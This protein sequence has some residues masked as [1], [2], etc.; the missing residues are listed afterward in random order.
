QHQRRMRRQS[1][2]HDL[3]G[4]AQ[5]VE[6]VW[7][8]TGDAASQDLRLPS[9][10]RDL[11]ALELLQDLKRTVDIVK[12]CAC[13]DVL[14]GEHKPHEVGRAYRLDFFA[15]ASQRQTMDAS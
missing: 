9:R 2:P 13:R 3:T 12:R 5:P 11:V 6:Q 4:K 1:A 14:P 8:I 15:Q 10:G 7:S